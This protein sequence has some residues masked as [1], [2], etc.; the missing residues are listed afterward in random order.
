MLIISL[1]LYTYTLVNIIR[2]NEHEVCAI[3]MLE[4]LN[5]IYLFINGHVFRD[6]RD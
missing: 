1:S 3:M 2:E 4:E 5:F 6:A